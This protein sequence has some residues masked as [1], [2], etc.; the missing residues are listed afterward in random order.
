MI[1]DSL[2]ILDLKSLKWKLQKIDKY[3]TKSKN[4]SDVDISRA[5]YTSYLVDHQWFI[6][7]GNYI[8]YILGISKYLIKFPF[9]IIDLNEF[10]LIDQYIPPIVSWFDKPKDFIKK[11][12][13][14][15]KND[16]PNRI[17]II[18]SVSTTILTILVVLVVIKIRKVCEYNTKKDIPQI[19][20]DP[21]FCDSVYLYDITLCSGELVFLYGIDT[22]LHNDSGF[23][24]H[25]LVPS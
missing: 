4:N 11:E 16:S 2:Y 25:T 5:S 6:I 3:I 17:N 1:Y 13:D 24:S 14:T 21:L 10:K 22:Y 19:Y 23:P 18:I 7:Y 12:I 15:D 9:F 20:F 8:S